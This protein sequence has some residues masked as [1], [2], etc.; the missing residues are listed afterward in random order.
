MSNLK[1]EAIV[2][3]SNDGSITLTTHRLLQRTREINKEVM[4]TDFLAYEQITKRSR[5]YTI[6]TIV[7]FI[8]ATIL[9]IY[10]NYKVNSSETL[11]GRFDMTFRDNLSDHLSVKEQLEV[12]GSCAAFATLIFVISF[13]LYLFSKCNF[14]KVV[15]KYSSIEFSTRNLKNDSF[16]RF[17][18]SLVVESDKRKREI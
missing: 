4:L 14:L 7:F 12:Y 13:L 2:M 8:I 18:N 9:V 15:G 5:Y 17:T 3:S 11:R 1:D 6:L 10:Y 16:N